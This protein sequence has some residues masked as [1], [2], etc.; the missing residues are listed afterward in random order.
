MGRP[1][2]QNRYSA[3]KILT[4]K[5]TGKRPLGNSR[6]KWVNNINMYLK[7]ICV[8]MKNWVGSD[9]NGDYWRP[10]WMRHCNAQPMN[11]HRAL[12][13]KSLNRPHSKRSLGHLKKHFVWKFQFET[14]RSPMCNSGQ[15]EDI[16]MNH[17]SRVAATSLLFKRMST[18]WS[19][20][21]L[22]PMF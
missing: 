9:Q 17:G 4:G 5:P 6:H 21:L 1:C 11:R 8:K 15:E 18:F 10:L 22:A 14:N 16:L 3:L 2:G 12:E 19:N 13:D 20:Y 7:E